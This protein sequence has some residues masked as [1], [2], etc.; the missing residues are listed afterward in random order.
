[1]ATA[2]GL[3]QGKY[4]SMINRTFLIVIKVTNIIGRN[5]TRRLI[6]LTPGWAA[7]IF[8]FYAMHCEAELNRRN[9]TQLQL[10]RLWTS[11]ATT[12]EPGGASL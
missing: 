9:L 10:C 8:G 2:G 5:N 1:M 4:F 7:L 12:S 6:F 11:S 3:T